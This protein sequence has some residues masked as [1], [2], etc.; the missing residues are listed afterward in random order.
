MKA[1]VHTT[2]GY[3]RTKMFR[4][5]QRLWEDHA[6]YPKQLDAVTEY[7]TSYEAK[8]L[9]GYACQLHR[10]WNTLG[11]RARQLV[12]YVQVPEAKRPN[13]EALVREY[14]TMFVSVVEPGDMPS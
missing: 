2:E 4:L 9:T 14:L 7:L 12:E 13:A 1:N 5:K 6:A 3:L 10:E 11:E 8:G